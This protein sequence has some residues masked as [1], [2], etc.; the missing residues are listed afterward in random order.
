MAN[1]TYTIHGVARHF[2]NLHIYPCGETEKG[3]AQGTRYRQGGYLYMWERTRKMT[4]AHTR[5]HKT[6]NISR[7]KMHTH[8]LYPLA[9]G[10][11]Q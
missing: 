9:I 3:N 4:H 8:D 7:T 1:T 6:E 2:I 10:Y 11:I 5:T